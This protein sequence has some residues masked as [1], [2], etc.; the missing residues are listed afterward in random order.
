M[1]TLAGRVIKRCFDF[2]VAAGLLALL[3]PLL[4]W[5]AVAI[6]RQLPGPAVFAQQRAGHRGRPFTFYKF[7]TM[8]GEVDPYGRS[9]AS[10]EDPRL[11]RV[12]R[13]LRE[14]SLDE[15]PQLLN[16]LRG[17]MSLVGPRPLYL[18]QAE[19]W[20]ARQRR[21]LDAKPGI[22]G[23]AQIRDRAE[24]THEDKIEMDLEYVERSSL[25]LDFR[26][27]LATVARVRRRQSIYETRPYNDETQAW[28]YSPPQQAEHESGPEDSA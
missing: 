15:L 19:R 5:I 12:G 17:D 16:V 2:V 14:R 8:R 27:L 10:A 20:N 6:R 18:Q 13:W 23:L 7:R 11:T 4:L 9:P 3:S 28:D 1:H 22:T 26:I 24:M 25:W 21:R